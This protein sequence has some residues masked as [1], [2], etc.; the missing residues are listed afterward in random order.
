MNN[1]NLI[2]V[3]FGDDDFF[4]D[5]KDKGQLILK[6]PFGVFKSTKKTNKIVVR[7]SALAQGRR[8]VHGYFLLLL[9]K[10]SI[11]FTEKTIFK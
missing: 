3:D 8:K 7:I 5:F 1:D 10:S 9:C 2:S 6:F 11:W 4:K